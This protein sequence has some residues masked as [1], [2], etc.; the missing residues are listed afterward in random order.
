MSRYRALRLLVPLLLAA[1]TTAGAADFDTSFYAPPDSRERLPLVVDGPPR[2]VILLIGDGM[3]TAQVA[4]ARYAALGPQGRLHM[5]RMPVTGFLATHPADAL[6][7][8]SAA[9]GTAMACGVKTR[10]GCVA[11]SPEGEEHVSILELA[12]DAGLATGLVATST[13]THAT[14]ACFAAHELH[15]ADE[16]RIAVD[17]AGSAVDVILGG[18]RCYW[19][20]ASMAGSARKDELDLLGMM[21][22]RGYAVVTD[23]AGMAA[24]QT[25]RMLGLFRRGSLRAEGSTDEEPSL[26]EMTAKAISLLDL[27][28]EGF[29]LMVEGSQIDWAGHEGDAEGVVRQTLRF[30]EA[31][32]EALAFALADGQ[33]L[34]IVTADHETGGLSLL[35]E[36]T[37]RMEF[38]T[39]HHSAIPVP[40]FAYG[41]G[42][43]Q[44]T[45]LLDNTELAVRLA[46]LLSLPLRPDR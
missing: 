3:G 40:L 24:T 16:D 28:P 33:T 23:R 32:A 45:G 29:F 41:P 43:L 17:M 22:R 46:A 7:T 5:E 30:D 10:N 34:V 8:D 12:R 4:A 21:S 31:V 39:D 26:R 37:M 36:E 25:G 15:R 42:A 2:K 1:F 38:A 27:D 35:G 6:I 13:V 20:P 14:P 19:L 9:A 44:F 18:G 11:V